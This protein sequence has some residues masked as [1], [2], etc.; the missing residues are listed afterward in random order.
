M[1]GAGT[2]NI[3]RL[4]RQDWTV[5]E[6][7]LVADSD[8]R[9]AVRVLPND[10]VNRRP[11]TAAR[12]KRATYLGVRLNAMLGEFAVGPRGLGPSCSLVVLCV[13]RI[14]LC[15]GALAVDGHWKLRCRDLHH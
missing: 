2:Q 10:Q 12:Q 14:D 8:R 13:A 3:L 9:Q 6:R 4:R 5:C 7:P 15:R 1:E 11:A